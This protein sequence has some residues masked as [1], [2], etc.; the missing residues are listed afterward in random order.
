MPVSHQ[1]LTLE[2]RSS[3][4]A[5]LPVE[6]NGVYFGESQMPWYSEVAYFIL[7]LSTVDSLSECEFIFILM[8]WIKASE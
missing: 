7:G 1:S 2:E 4:L 6:G 5:W 3:S 8:V